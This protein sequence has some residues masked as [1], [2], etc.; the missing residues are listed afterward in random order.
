MKI[1]V[2]AKLRLLHSFILLTSQTLSLLPSLLQLLLL[3]I[4]QRAILRLTFTLA[5][6]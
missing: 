3:N 5:L 2:A 1:A 4:P 6:T